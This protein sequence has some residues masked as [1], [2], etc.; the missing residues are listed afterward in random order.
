VRSRGSVPLLVGGTGLYHRAI[1]DD[2]AIPPSFPELRASLEGQATDDEAI[3]ALHARLVELDPLA[4]TRTE[5][6]N[7]RRIVRALEVT[8]GSGRPFSSFGPGL[9]TYAPNGWTMVGLT[10][11]RPDLDE[12]IALRL[13]HQFAD[14]FVEETAGLLA[15]PGGLSRTVRQALGYREL[16]AHLEGRASI[17]QTR[18]AILS[19]TRSFARR[20]EA[21]FRRDPRIAW[22]DARR[23]DLVDAV[24]TL[25]PGEQR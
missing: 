13:E 10:L 25:E 8:L 11:P 20:Q 2:L 14:G 6:T 19:R 17:S 4:S 15:R 7:A 18:S 9:R 21:W 23:G 22:F 12:R 3:R 5:P 24:A 16:I 1:V